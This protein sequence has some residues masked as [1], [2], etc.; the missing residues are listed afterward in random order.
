MSL[1]ELHKS[2]KGRCARMSAVSEAHLHIQTL[3][4]DMDPA[5]LAIIRS[6]STKPLLFQL[7]SAVINA[8]HI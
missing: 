3:L 1:A 6:F 7:E 5:S 8:M 4:I 2:R